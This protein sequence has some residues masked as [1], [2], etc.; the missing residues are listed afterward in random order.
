M[1]VDVEVSGSTL[2]ALTPHELFEKAS[3]DYDVSL[4]GNRFLMM[5]PA[6]GAGTSTQPNELHLIPNW[7]EELRR[8]VPLE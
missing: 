8:L 6:T 3:L 5:K 1:A 2:R 4:D 7:D